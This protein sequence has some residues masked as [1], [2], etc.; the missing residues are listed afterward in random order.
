[1][2]DQPDPDL[3]AVNEEGASFHPSGTE[4]AKFAEAIRRG[5]VPKTAD[6][7]EALEKLITSARR[8]AGKVVRS[9]FNGIGPGQWGNR[10][11]P[12]RMN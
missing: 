1:M 9:V 12:N 5:D 8:G 7:F 4:A 2:S 6:S 11:R 3:I 10:K